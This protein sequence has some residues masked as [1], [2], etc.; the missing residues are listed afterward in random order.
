ML[1]AAYAVDLVRYVRFLRPTSSIEDLCQEVW[2]AAGRALPRFR[3]ESTPRTWLFGI[4]RHRLSY[5]R[6]RRRV[7]RLQPLP[8][9]FEA[10]E[11]SLRASPIWIRQDPSPSSGLRRKVRSTTLGA[12]LERL[13]PDERELVELRFVAGLKP[14]AIVEVLALSDSAN[15]VSQRLV[16]LIRTLRKRLE[17]RKEFEPL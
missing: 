13:G 8:P 16:R 14:A 10:L 5:E 2:L 11:R 9:D 12:E 17:A 7:R 4:A 6:R 15:T 3:F 1:H